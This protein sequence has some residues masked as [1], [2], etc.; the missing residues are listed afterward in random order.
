M[1]KKWVTPKI[2]SILI[3]NE[4]IDGFPVKHHSYSSLVLLM[5]NPFMYKVK[6]INGDQIETTRNPSAFIG[7]ALHKAL[8]HYY[9]TEDDTAFATGLD[10]GLEYIKN[11][12][13]GLIAWSDTIKGK[14]DVEKK[15]LF[16]YN[17]YMKEVGSK[18]RVSKVVAVEKSIKHK[19]SVDGKVLPVPLKAIPDLVF[20]DSKG[21]IIIDDHKAVAKFSDPDKIEG[22]KLIQ[23]VT[24][25]LCVA[26]EYGKFPTKFV[27]TEVKHTENRDKNA[28]QVQRY[29]IELS[30]Y[31]IMFD[32]F[33]R[34]YED[35]NN[36]LLGNACFLPNIDTFFDNEA[37][38]VAY[39]HRL[40]IE[41][42][43]EEQ[44][45]RYD[46]TN[47]TDLLKRKI[48]DSGAMKR[49]LDTVEKEFISAETLNYKDMTPE[50]RIQ[51]KLQEHG[52]AL[53][54]DSAVEG[55]SVRLYRYEASIGVKMSRIEQ[56]SKDIEQALGK[57]NVRILAP[58]P[59]SELIGFEVPKDKAERIPV[60]NNY[61]KAHGDII[62]GVDVY[63]KPI[64][65]QVNSLPH[66]LVAGTTGSG[67]SYFLNNIYE[68]LKN[69]FEFVIIDPKGTEFENGI[70]EIELIHSAV[71][72]LESIMQ[73]RFAEM[74]ER[75]IKKWDKISTIV[76]V[77]EY[78][79][80]KMNEDYG[81]EIDAIIKK[82]AQKA[83]AAGIHIILATQR[84]STRVIDGDIK[85][86]FPTRICFRL[87]TDTD[88]RVVLDQGGAETLLGQGD[89]LLS[90]DGV[91]TRFQSFV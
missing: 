32:F 14:A 78:N 35:A 16:A 4:N 62:I 27:F 81:K 67:K 6:Y 63:N 61:K 87:P 33:Y 74:K 83:R 40:D 60:S 90:Y 89:G 29:E 36:M 20:E 18:K 73:Q 57:Q 10:K 21:G 54:F 24:T 68:Q 25:T 22:R 86:N 58:I 26:A 56:F 79:D 1:R 34:V 91:I 52:I 43:K 30:K 50:T 8:E 77:D 13:D 11:E 71:Y 2:Q 70:S 51:M 31:P 9:K 84:P 65:L 53:K 46:V 28:P 49:Y 45:K 23:V 41:N 64:T 44:Y 55:S 82:L 66:L 47:I 48:H 80:I 75:K 38:I 76:L 19:V 85:A 17:A 37:S 15:F 3:N 88:S 5:T 39:A 7:S 59:N 12:P 42:V 72:R 69:E